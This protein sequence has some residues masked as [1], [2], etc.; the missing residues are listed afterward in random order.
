MAMTQHRPITTIP[1][2]PE[3]A[4]FWDA[5]KNEKLLLGKCKAC[6]KLH[7]YPRALCPFCF[8]DTEYQEASGQGTIYSY[9]VMR[10]VPIPYVFA[11]V[12]LAEGV[13][14]VTNIVDCNMDK[15]KIGD[16]VR[17]VFKPTEDGGKIAMF[18]PA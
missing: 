1:A 10:K 13:T 15:L 16:P 18:T 4:K 6:G 3:T 14:M 12:T 9:T 5:A 8:G 17:L 7:Y 11:Y 2:N